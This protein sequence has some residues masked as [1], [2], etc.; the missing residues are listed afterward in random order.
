MCKPLM[1]CGHTANATTANN[2]PCC[3]ICGC[4]EISERPKLDGRKAKCCFCGNIVNSDYNLPFFEYRA[5]KEYDLYYDG[6]G[7]WE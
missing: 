5:K 4:Y 3:A 7:G 2:E 1:K 6:C